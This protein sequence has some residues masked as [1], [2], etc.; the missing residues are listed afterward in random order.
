M[1]QLGAIVRA[2]PVYELTVSRD[3]SVVDESVERVIAWHTQPGASQSQRIS[4]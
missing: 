4:A 3:W 2:V 1:K